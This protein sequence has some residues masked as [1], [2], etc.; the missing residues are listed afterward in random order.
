MLSQRTHPATTLFPVCFLAYI[1]WKRSAPG[2]KEFV[3]KQNRLEANSTIELDGNLTVGQT[4]ETVEVSAT[5]EVL[6]TESGA[7]QAEVTGQV[8]STI[9]N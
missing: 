9:R 8:R 2:F 7:V 6:Q 4:S 1:R 3:S 5:A